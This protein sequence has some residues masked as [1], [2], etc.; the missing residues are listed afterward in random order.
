M[1][2]KSGGAERVCTWNSLQMIYWGGGGRRP[3]WQ[4]VL[5]PIFLANAGSTS[6]S[7]ALLRV[8]FKEY[9]I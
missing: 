7:A 9:S 5:C 4:E 3:H 6:L 8:N 2:W 1:G